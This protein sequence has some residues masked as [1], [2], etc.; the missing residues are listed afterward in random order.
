MVWHTQG[1]TRVITAFY[2]NGTFAT[3]PNWDGSTYT[4]ADN[5]T[6]GFIT[7]E[8]GFGYIWSSHPSVRDALGWATATEQGYIATY[9][10]TRTF[11]KYEAALRYLTLPDG[12]IIRYQM[13]YGGATQWAYLN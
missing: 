12:R 4:F 5:P 6:D 3:F 8:R 10:S 1:N 11:Q 9:Q 13:D 2:D 7:P